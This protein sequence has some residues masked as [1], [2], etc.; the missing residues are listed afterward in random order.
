K[1]PVAERRHVIGEHALAVGS[2]VRERRRHVV[3]GRLQPRLQ[4][5]IEGEH[6]ADPAH[7]QRPLESVGT[8]SIIG[9]VGHSAGASTGISTARFAK[10]SSAPT[11]PN[12]SHV[13]SFTARLR[14]LPPTTN[15]AIEMLRAFA[16]VF[17]NALVR[18]ST[19]G[20]RAS[21]LTRKDA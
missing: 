15:A 18:G 6:S 3:N 8:L 9:I 13:R 19:C 7:S 14:K 11:S 20:A 5:A 4:R 1:A 2:A 17:R 10:R 12:V 16:V 21:R